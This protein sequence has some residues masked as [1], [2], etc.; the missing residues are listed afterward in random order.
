MRP[1]KRSALLPTIIV[2]AALVIV[3][4]IFSGTYTDFLWFN[5]LGFSG[6]FWTEKVAKLLIF[7]AAFLVM[8]L[9]VYFSIRVAY[10]ARPVYAPDSAREDNLNRYQLQLEPVR[11]VVMIGVPVVFGLFAGTAAMAQWDKVMLFLYRVPFGSTDPEFGLDISFYT[12]TLPF[13]G[14]VVGMLISATVIAF[15]AGLL[16][17]YLYGAIRLTERGIFASRQA[18]IHIAIMAGVFLLLLGANF[19]LGRFATLQDNGGYRAGAMFTDVNAVIPTKAILA[20]AAIIVAILFI[21]AAFIGKWKLPLIGTGM[22]VVTAIVAGGIYPWAVQEWQVKPSEGNVE[23][24]YIERNINM[25]RDAYGLSDME[26]TPYNATTTAEAGAL[27]QD[28]D[29]AANIRLLDPNLI[30]STFAQLEQFRPYYKFPKTLNVDRYTIDGKVQDAVI[31]VRELNP[32][33]INPNQQSWYNQHLVYTH[34]YGV[35]A[36][37]GNKVTADGKPEFMQ[38]GVPSTGVLGSDTSYQPRIYFG[39]STTDYSIVGAPEGTDPIE[40]DRPQGSST[41]SGADDPAS[42]ALTTFTGD[43]GPN[44]GNWFNRVMYAL[45]FQSTDLLL[46]NGVNEK[47]QIL[48]DRT[49]AERVAKVAPYLTLDG[50]P[51]PAIVDG[52]VKWIVDGY[53]T[54]SN[55]P[56]S[57]QQ[58]LQEA[59]TDSLTVNG[60]AGAL[61]NTSVNYIRNSVKATVDAYDGSVD[62][63]AWDAQD[64]ILKAWQNVFPTTVKPF[65]EMSGDLMAHVRYPEDLFKVQRELLGRYHVTNPTNFFKN[66]L[67][68]SVPDDPTTKAVDKQP[69]YYLSLKMPGKDKTAFSLTTDF[70]PQE[71]QNTDSRNILYGFM[72]ANGDAGNVKGV[73]SPDYGKLQLLE[74]PDATQVPGPGQVQNTF[75]SNTSVSEQLNVLKLGQSDVINGNLLTLPMGGGMLYVQPVYVKSTG[76]TSYPTLQKVLVAFGNKIGYADTLNEALDAL[77]GGDSGAAAGDAGVDKGQGSGGS[78][79][80]GGKPPAVSSNPALAAALTDANKA[81]Q[82]GQAALAKGDF[83]AYGEAQKALETALAAAIAAEGATATTAPTAT[84]TPSAAP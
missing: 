52:K 20:A 53:T 30:S 29:T 5:Q 40:L 75:Q 79:T 74:L 12:N 25:T 15:I 43:A 70:I 33:G 32:E 80:D 3:L 27:R 49:P 84:P 65:T 64:P 54:S 48:Y 22:L 26:V 46:T 23:L 47:S 7:L 6:V 2:V 35:V 51:Y 38:S 9:A 77:F 13:L 72:A 37:Y 39:Q 82:D 66:T 61:P 50:N 11:R 68:W 45:K 10:K 44:L 42:E 31:A 62:L 41:T 78:S 17:H 36:A 28:A 57:Q 14:F 83:A 4:L 34:G 19:W 55:Y 56:Y 67:A 76:S 58:Q 59:T 21:V 81:L 18:Q 8:A 16:T 71:V 63:Y 69:P 60:G 24:P 73:K 1:K